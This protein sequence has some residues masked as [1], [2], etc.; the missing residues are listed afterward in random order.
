MPQWLHV[1]SRGLQVSGT[2]FGSISARAGGS[3]IT[4][5]IFAASFG[6]VGRFAPFGKGDVCVVRHEGRSLVSNS[7][8]WFLRDLGA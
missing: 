1:T 4:Y 6:Y 7:A 8:K 5:H 2:G 3:C